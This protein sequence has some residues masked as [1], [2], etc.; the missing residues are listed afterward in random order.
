[1]EVKD[2]IELLSAVPENWEVYVDNP[3]RSEDYFVDDVWMGNKT[4]QV[5]IQTAE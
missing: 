1:M 5:F 2:L 4:H 3:D